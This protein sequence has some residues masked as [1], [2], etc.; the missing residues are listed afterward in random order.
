M[1]MALKVSNKRKGTSPRFFSKA[2]LVVTILPLWALWVYAYATLRTLQSEVEA[3]PHFYGMYLYKENVRSRLEGA[4]QRMTRFEDQRGLDIEGGRVEGLTETEGES[5]DLL[6][7]LEEALIVVERAGFRIL[8][9]SEPPF[10]AAGFLGEPAGREAFLRTLQQ[11]DANGLRSGYLSIDTS[12][13]PDRR[14][15]RCWFLTMAPVGEALLSVL[16]VPEERVR[17]SAGI[18][19]EAKENLL[20]QRRKRF[21]RLTLPVVVLSSL[22]IVILYRQSRQSNRGGGT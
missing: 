11:M 1:G 9:P 20:E 17:L 10:G 2:A 21:V 14:N 5:F 6:F 22:F 12:N 7:G 8:H 16:S 13:T 4:A 15:K 19:E 3:L 18:L